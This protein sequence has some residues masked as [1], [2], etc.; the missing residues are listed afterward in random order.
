MVVFGFVVV[1]VVG[2]IAPFTKPPPKIVFTPWTTTT[3]L[4]LVVS[5]PKL[6][7]FAGC[8]GIV[9]CGSWV[10]VSART[11]ATVTMSQPC[12]ARTSTTPADITP[13]VYVKWTT[14][15]AVT[16]SAHKPVTVPKTPTCVDVSRRI[17]IALKPQFACERTGVF[18]GGVNRCDDRCVLGVI[19]S[20]VRGHQ[21]VVPCFA[22]S[23]FSGFAIIF[24]VYLWSYP[25]FGVTSV[26]TTSGTDHIECGCVYPTRLMEKIGVS[27]SG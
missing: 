25:S 26:L 8:G 11:M 20:T 23:G 22:W 18:L 17:L 1:S 10:V 2:K 5:P 4:V 3:L 15:G 9:A 19:K 27:L 21:V 6:A 24:I 13:V 16:T 14:F 12:M 7:E